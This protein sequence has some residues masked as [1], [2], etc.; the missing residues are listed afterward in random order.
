MYNQVKALLAH[1][2]NEAPLIETVPYPI[3]RAGESIIRIEAAV[4]S[5]LDLT[6]LGGE[7]DIRPQLPYIGG[8]EGAGK[9]IE[10]ESFEVGTRVAARGGGI[11]LTRAGTWAEY[12]A[13]PDSALRAVSDSL[14]PEIAA[15]SFSPLTTAYIALH[16]IGRLVR[17]AEQY[18]ST[19][20]AG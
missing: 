14:R 5:H 20:A 13:S 16:D 12:V 15:T 10:S 4:I 11:G 7:F 19:L 6:V 2:W 3:R 17:T 1:R 9:V 18:S 8:V